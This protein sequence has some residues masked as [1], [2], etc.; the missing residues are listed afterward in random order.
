MV[1]DW[2]VYYGDGTTYSSQDGEPE[3]APPGNVMCVV[4][5]DEDNRRKIAH[6][7]YAYVWDG[8]WYGADD[9]GYWQYMLEPGVK[10]VKFGRMNKDGKFRKIMS[11]ADNE[12]PVERGV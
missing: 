5:Y 7:A 12:N 6:N 8:F 9:A 11:R 1:L 10:I 3:D 2:R 4:W